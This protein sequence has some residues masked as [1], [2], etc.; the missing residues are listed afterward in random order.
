MRAGIIPLVTGSTIRS[1]VVSEDRL[2]GFQDDPLRD[3]SN[4]P[5][6]IHG[7]DL[8]PSGFDILPNNVPAVFDVADV[9]SKLNGAVEITWSNVA[10][11][12]KKFITNVVTGTIKTQVVDIY[13][14]ENSQKADRKVMKLLARERDIL[15]KISL[16]KREER[17]EQDL[18]L[19]GNTLYFKTKLYPD[20]QIA[21][22]SKNGITLRHVTDHSDIAPVFDHVL[23]LLNNYGISNTLRVLS[24][25]IGDV[26]ASFDTMMHVDLQRLSDFNHYDA[27]YKPQ[28]FS[29]VTLV[30]PPNKVRAS[31]FESGKV[32]LSN[33]TLFGE[34]VG[35]AGLVTDLLYSSDAWN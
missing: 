30:I 19:K 15:K 26:C 14:T 8:N 34:A 32:L 5:D 4:D 12:L 17:W 2:A 10:F 21:L 27:V 9:C 6:W 11:D 31:V 28:V 33:M 29:G 18:L 23:V 22:T 7:D 35:A 3:L 20:V 1:V 24:Y 13:N 16:S 25:T